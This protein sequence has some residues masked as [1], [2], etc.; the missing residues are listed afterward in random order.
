MEKQDYPKAS[1]YT[2]LDTIY[3]QC[4]G[5]GG[6]KVAE[7]IA[8]KMGLSKSKRLLDVGCNR[9]YQSCFL[10]KEYGLSVTGIDPW[11]DRMDG[12]PMIDHA[13][14]NAEIWGV[15]NA[16]LALKTGVPETG[17][18]TS[19]FDF[20]YSTTALE[21]LRVMNGEEGYIACLKEISR[22]LK[23]GGT[24][25]LGEPMHLDVDIPAD[26]EP[27][28]SQSEYPWKECFSDLSTTVES[29]KKAGFE[30]IESAYA[31][32]SRDW[33]LEYAKHDPFCKAK[34]DEDP[35]T[36]EID[37]GRWVSFGYVIA[38]NPL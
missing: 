28:V 25:G 23:P 34:P 19:S 9:G 3:A 21:M 33:W 7:F 31:P 16:F 20:V 32:D 8:E 5:P 38:R 17:F 2:D 36:L 4:S 30:V 13:R 18:A 6:L 22:V 10:A 14:E 24:F 35:K 1:K 12:R 29:V 27:Y 15:A 37:R 11:D 26:L